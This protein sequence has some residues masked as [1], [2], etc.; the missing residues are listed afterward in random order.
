MPPPGPIFLG[1]EVAFL[2]PP[3]K[4]ID[5][6]VLSRA[7]ERKVDARYPAME[8][9]LTEQM[10]R[11]GGV[12]TRQEHQVS[13]QWASTAAAAKLSPDVAAQPRPSGGIRRRFAGWLAGTD[14]LDPLQ[15]AA[16]SGA[17]G[18]G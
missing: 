12:Q 10:P 14:F 9:L 15:R 3:Q 17:C 13:A 18:N 7:H 2:I 8:K 5:L 6:D 16:T 1:Q 11:V 4:G